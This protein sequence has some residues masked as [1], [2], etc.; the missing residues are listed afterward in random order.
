MVAT[1]PQFPSTSNPSPL[2]PFFALEAQRT[3]PRPAPSRATLP[4]TAEPAADP[5]GQTVAELLTYY[6]AEVLPS[7]A[8]QT[9]Y[10]QT[11]FLSML[12]S[13]FGHL[14]LTAMT[15]A[16]LRSWRDQLSRRLKPDTVRQYMD[17]YSAVLTV[18]VYELAWLPEHPMRGRK[19]RKPPA[20]RGRVRF[21]SP[22]EQ[23]RL[24]EA[25]RASHKPGL[26]PLVLLALCTGARRGELFSLRWQAVDLEWGWLG[27]E[28]T[29][30]KQPRAVP[31]PSVA[32][33]MLRAWRHD[34]ADTAWVFPRTSRT[35]FP[36]EY[37]WQVALLRAGLAGSLRFHD[38]RHSFAS[39][40]AMS[41]ASLIEIAEILGHKTLAM[42]RRYSH[43]T[44]EHT[45]GVVEKM[46]HQFILPVPPQEGAP[47]AEL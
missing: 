3:Q 8:P 19:V 22:V 15:P 32:L 24:L 12:A 28:H 4:Q 37:A 43:F 44:R 21:L 1:V 42:V 38:L 18:G 5:G 27:F 17:S 46:A 29:K 39:N 30:N 13:E 26:Y 16:W 23:E 10:Q 2:L 34:A 7:K 35:P 20:S 11:R 36:Y 41:G 33:E 14:P 9:Q 47:H 25:C 31:V 45:A 40:L 6:M